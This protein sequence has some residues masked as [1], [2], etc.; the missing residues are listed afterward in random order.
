MKNQKAREQRAVSNPVVRVEDMERNVDF[1]VLEV[2]ICFYVKH[3]AVQKLMLRT[4]RYQLL[5][6]G[7][8]DAVCRASET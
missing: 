3:S 2:F 1:K 8:R 5:Y 6:L 7:A 4:V